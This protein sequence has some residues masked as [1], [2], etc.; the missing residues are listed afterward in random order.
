MVNKIIIA[1]Y[2]SYSDI[3]EIHAHNWGIDLSPPRR[4]VQKSSNPHGSE[5]K[6]RKESSNDL[7]PPRIAR[8]ISNIGMVL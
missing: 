8:S 2:I 3:N 1:I 5:R 7:S 4:D 6:S